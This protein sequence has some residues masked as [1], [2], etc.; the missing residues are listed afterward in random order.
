MLDYYILYYTLLYI[1][2]GNQI[3]FGAYKLINERG[4]KRKLLIHK[5]LF[6]VLTFLND[7]S[8]MLKISTFW[9]LKQFLK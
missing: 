3:H 8:K 9:A 4:K 5:F 7:K 6:S 2:K 1:L